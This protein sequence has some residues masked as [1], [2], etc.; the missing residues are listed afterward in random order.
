MLKFFECYSLHNKYNLF[1]T[2]IK[3]FRSC[4]ESFNKSLTLA[5]SSRFVEEL[6]L[7]ESQPTEELCFFFVRKPR[8]GHWLTPNFLSKFRK[9]R[10]LI[11]VT[12]FPKISLQIF[13][14]NC[15]LLY[16][17]ARWF[18]AS[19]WLVAVAKTQ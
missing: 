11:Y 15:R 17:A 2:I 3:L 1:V 5:T 10:N 6:F 12:S 7:K 19:D 4:C 18:L 9:S 8:T 14:R 13:R 16:F